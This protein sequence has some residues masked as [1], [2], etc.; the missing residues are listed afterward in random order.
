MKIGIVGSGFV[1]SAAAYAMV[2]Q[3]GIVSEIVLIDRNETRARAEVADIS[4][5]VPFSFSIKINAGNYSDL[6]NCSVVIITAGVNQKPGESRLHLLE[7][8]ASVFRGIIPQILDNAPEAVLVVATNPVDIMT[9]ITARH[10]GEYGVPST[11]VIG[12]GTILDT[13]RFK[14]LVGG[15]LG[16]DPQHVHGYVVGEHGDSEVLTWSV[17]R[18]GGMPLEE[19]CFL[20]G[21]RCDENAR[22]EID[23]QVRRAAYAIIEGKGATYYGVG[24]ALARIVDV[25]EHDQRAILTVSTPMSNIAG[26]SDVTVSL[27]HLVGGE[28]ILATF[29]LSLSE[30]EDAALAASATI[31]KRAIEELDGK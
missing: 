23:N 17:A 14:S 9:H 3:G 8:N 13:A 2:M 20:K 22:L 12:S 4:H 1:G 27:P 21:V 11:R 16:V 31:V 26:V 30:P 19:F 25:I 15:R 29:P 28:G 10:A 5:A 7:R 6:V 18:I 24:A